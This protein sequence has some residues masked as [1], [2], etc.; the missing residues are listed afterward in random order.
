MEISLVTY[1]NI[2]K[3]QAVPTKVDSFSNQLSHWK[4]NEYQGTDEENLIQGGI[5]R[6]LPG[7]GKSCESCQGLAK[8]S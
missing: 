5:L 4:Q 7:P 6:I 3:M 8:N 1:K 2:L